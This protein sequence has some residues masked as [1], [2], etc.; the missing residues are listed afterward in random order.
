MVKHMEYSSIWL[1]LT[2]VMSTGASGLHSI[3]HKAFTM[4]AE[5]ASC[6]SCVPSSVCWTKGITQCF[7]P[8]N[9]QNKTD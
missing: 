8:P 6:V 2:A 1:T 7:Q 5:Q 4:Q 3:T 9:N